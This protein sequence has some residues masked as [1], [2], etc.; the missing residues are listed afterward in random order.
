MLLATERYPGGL[1]IDTVRYYLRAT[2]KSCRPNLSV[3]LICSFWSSREAVIA[4]SGPGAA[5][6]DAYSVIL[7]NESPTVVIANDYQSSADQLL[8]TC[9][10]Y[11]AGGGTNFAA[12]LDSAQQVMLQNVS[13]L[14][15][16]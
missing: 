16:G 10:A 4:S 12:A 11:S 3:V 14:F 5:R 2:G 13:L 9:L 8:D 15:L 7:F 1:M 6:R